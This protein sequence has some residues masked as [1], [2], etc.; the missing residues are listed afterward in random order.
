MLRIAAGAAMLDD[1]P[2]SSSPERKVCFRSGFSPSI[3]ISQS[4]ASRLSSGQTPH[5]SRRRFRARLCSKVIAIRRLLR[6]EDSVTIRS[7]SRFIPAMAALSPRSLMFITSMASAASAA[8]PLMASTPSEEIRKMPIPLSWGSIFT[9]CS[10]RL[11]RS[12]YIALRP[13]HSFP[14]ASR[15]NGLQRPLSRTQSLPETYRLRYAVQVCRSHGLQ[16]IH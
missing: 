8:Q 4:R 14:S 12:S 9:S 11:F 7:I 2:G 6:S 13:L 3:A 15:E 5:H 1:S 16:A 10:S